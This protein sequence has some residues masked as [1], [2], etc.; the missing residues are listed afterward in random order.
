M[1]TVDYK[2]ELLKRLAD[3]EYAAGYLNVAL[4]EGEDVFLLAMRDVVEARGGVAKLA[5]RTG[6]N[7]VTLYR[8]LSKKGNPT[9]ATLGTLMQALG[10]AIGCR[11]ASARG[12]KAA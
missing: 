2:E 3:T 5:K 7:R 10:L 9:L 12:K 1:P 6:L 4:E 11:P 8:L